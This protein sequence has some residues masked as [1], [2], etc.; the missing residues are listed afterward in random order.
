MPK[1]AFSISM[2][3]VWLLLPG[4]TASAQQP[5]LFQE[6][7]L[8]FAATR[9]DHV[10]LPSP[11]GIG[12][13][14]RWQVAD[15]WLL[16]LVYQ[17]SKEETRKIGTV[18]DQYSQRINC[19]QEPT[20]TTVTF[21]GLR[22]SFARAFRVGPWAEISLGGGMSFNSVKPEAVDLTG[23][24]ADMLVPNTGQIGYLASLSA[25]LAPLRRTP[26]M[27]VGGYTH[28]WVNFNGCSGEDPPQ[29]DPFCGWGILKEM[30]LGLSYVF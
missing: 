7:G 10:E 13:F 11:V 19:R 16:R 15:G 3:A 28:H 18:C 23:W 20:V 25:T 21:S 9:S 30:E 4:A 8:F 26:V 17:R 12:A 14:A 27:L 22:G 2:V 29:Y 1:T 24:M 6:L 5:G